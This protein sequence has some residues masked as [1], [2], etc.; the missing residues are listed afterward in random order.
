MVVANDQDRRHACS[1]PLRRCAGVTPHPGGGVNILSD[2]LTLFTLYQPIQRTGLHPVTDHSQ[3]Y[4][5]PAQ[6]SPIQPVLHWNVPEVE[7]VRIVS[8]G[9]FGGMYKV[10][11]VF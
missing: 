11:R 9:R 2:S 7:E 1:F 8:A 6:M 3:R 5:C 10:K 4:T